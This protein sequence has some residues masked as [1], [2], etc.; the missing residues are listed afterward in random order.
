[1]NLSAQRQSHLSHLI[2]DALCREG[3]VQCP[4]RADALQALKEAF[5]KLGA[6]EAE[7]DALIREKL[8][9]QRKVPGSR[10]WQ[11]LYDK[12]LQEEHHKRRF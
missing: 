9:K 1:M 6:A 2:L 5:A 12:Y 10:E 3:L 4:N 7:L 11:I 8:R